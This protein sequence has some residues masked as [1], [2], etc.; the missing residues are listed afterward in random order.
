MA[1]AL[2][3]VGS[4]RLWGNSE[5]V[6]RE[7]LLG[8]QE[9]GA[10]VEMLRLTDLSIE[11]CNGCLRCAI[12]EEPCPLDDDME[13]FLAK[14][15]ESDALVLSAPTYMLGPAAIVKLILDRL[16]M[17][18]PYFMEAARSTKPG[19]TIALSG[20]RDLRGVT[21]PFLNA[22]VM[23]LG[24]R[25][26]DSL[27]VHQPGPGEVLLDDEVM[28]RIHELGRRLARGEK[29]ERLPE[30][31]VCPVCWSDFFFLERERAICPVCGSEA[32]IGIEAGEVRL[33]F[34]PAGRRRWGYGWQREHIEGWIR[35]T[36]PRFLAHRE[37]IKARRER[38]REMGE[39]WVR[40]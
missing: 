36:V 6:V 39:I 37:E 28:V 12:R 40:P 23:G 38:Y 18:T 10:K 31:N 27:Y 22:L 29:G 15:R 8:A 30:G 17:L 7:A 32:Q 4:A 26:A 13:W 3:L 24:F 21:Q 5:I 1:T 16:L 9:E 25:L 14:V 35:L 19:A 20:R 2:G 33:A 34:Q 11:P